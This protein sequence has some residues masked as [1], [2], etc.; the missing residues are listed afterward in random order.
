MILSTLLQCCIVIAMQIKLT[1]VV[2]VVVVDEHHAFDIEVSMTLTWYDS[3]FIEKLGW[4]HR[5]RLDFVR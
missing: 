5:F 2:V 4:S 3:E 1:V